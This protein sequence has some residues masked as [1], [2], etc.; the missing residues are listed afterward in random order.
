LTGLLTLFA[1]NILPIFLAA[2]TGYLLSRF[3][4]VNPRTVSQVG[5]YIFTPCLVYKLL[6]TSQLSGSEAL[7]MAVFTIAST[8]VVGALTW[9]LGRLFKFD[10]RLLVAVLLVAMFS[11]AGNYG[12]SLNLFAFGETA[13][14]HASV[15]FVVSI[16]LTYTIG[17]VLASLGKSGLKEALLGM[18]KVPALYT[19]I[20]ALLSNAIQW[21]LPLPVERSV[22]L[23]GD[24]TIPTLLVLMGIQLGNSQWDGQR[25]ALGVANL[26][27]L[28]V[29]PAVALG[30]VLLL[31]L[32]GA[33]MQAAISESGA[34]TAVFMTILATEYEVEPSFVTAAV[35]TSTLLSPLT[36][37]PLIAWLGA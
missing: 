23:L 25:L 10:R 2:G 1:N 33:A 27:R 6:T 4:K 7:R 36:M 29:A 32:S 17:V 8:L 20:L 5:F 3:L 22:F 19:A 34:P 30:I 28:V 15:Y 31:G 26:M 37:T 21:K 12:L 11:N 35:F 16:V 13:V 18:F 14:A 9:A 24:A